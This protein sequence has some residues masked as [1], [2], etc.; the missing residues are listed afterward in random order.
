MSGDQ[1][2]SIKVWDIRLASGK[3]PKPIKE[4]HPGK[5]GGTPNSNNHNNDGNNNG[6]N[7]GH[8]NDDR[9]MVGMKPSIQSVDISED[10]RLAMAATHHAN[11]YLWDPTDMSH[12]K[13]L[14]K[15]RA[16]PHGAY[17]LKAKISPDGR[18]LVTTS[19]D[20]TAKL[21]NIQQLTKPYLTNQNTLQLRPPQVTK[22]LGQHERWVWDA[23]FSADSSYLVTACSD[24]WARLWNLQTGEV[25]R[26]Y[27]GHR[28]A[29]T[30]VALNDSST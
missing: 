29:V 25:V 7:N 3:L 8:N 28:S 16:H 1:D 23:V 27:T 9:T 19:S 11:V 5:D 14:R 10:G 13:P 17:L 6:N 20:K 18:H 4:L 2:G 22:L 24:T 30:C 21:W 26:Q 15:F 12:W